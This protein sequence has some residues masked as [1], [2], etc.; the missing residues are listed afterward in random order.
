M[1][2]TFLYLLVLLMPVSI[3]AQAP[4]ENY[5][6]DPASVEHAGVPKGEIIKV[7]FDSSKIFPG[8]WREYSIYVP[9][10]YDPAKPA[11]VWVNQDGIQFKA[12]TVFDNL[13]NSKEMPVTIGVFVTPGQVRATDAKTALNR[14]NR[15]FEYD[16]LGDAY[17]R[18][19][20]EEILPDVEKHKTSDGRAIRLSTSAAD[21]G[22]GGSSSG[23]IAAFNAA[24]ERPDAFSRV[25][26]S[27]GTYVGL[28]G[29]DRLPSLI[30]K[31]EAKPI[32]VFLQDG[33]NDNNSYAGDWFKANEMMER[34]LKFAGYQ[35]QAI[36][37]EGGHNG[38][39]ATA[40]F[41]QAMRFLWKDHPRPVTTEV[42]KNDVLKTITIPGQGWELVAEKVDRFGNLQ[43]NPAGEVFARAWDGANRVR[44][45]GVD[46]KMS[47]VKTGIPKFNDG[48][49]V[50]AYDG[51]KYRIVTGLGRYS[52]LVSTHPQGK[53]QAQK[54]WIRY[55]GGMVLTPD[56]TQ[57]YISDFSSHWIWIYRIGA[58]GAPTDGQKLGWLYMPDNAD[59]AEPSAMQCDTSGRLYVAT[60]MGVQVLDQIGKVNAIFPLPDGHAHS[61]CFGGANFDELYV[62]SDDKIYRRKLKVR[63]VNSFDAPVKPAKPRL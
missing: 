12:P 21:R 17:V 42:S 54:F 46:G 22:I 62:L 1:I 34:S 20:L 11:C 5:P 13:I 19:I 56:Q 48:A 50:T 35:V 6:E 33:S 14:Y 38:K 27:I 24:W 40:Y 7:T 28:R 31:Y 3:F 60:N 30:R 58:D 63:G 10:Q 52:K 36:Y 9:A 2:K 15:S 23:A 4:V 44:K 51:S 61:L 32:R 45:I 53:N 57:L 8:T 39:M 55:A 16:G 25:F 43:V 37:G 41:P 29:A 47:T 18:F 26:S 49:S 59:N